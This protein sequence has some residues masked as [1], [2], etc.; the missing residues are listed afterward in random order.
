M[1][2]GCPGLVIFSPNQL[3]ALGVAGSLAWA[4][5]SSFFGV[6]RVCSNLQRLRGFR[7]RPLPSDSPGFARTKYRFALL[8][9][10]ES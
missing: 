5:L 6:T 2:K 4:T 9:S 3:D 1:R 10:R 7:A 8:S